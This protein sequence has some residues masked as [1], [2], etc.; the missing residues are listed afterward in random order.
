MYDCLNCG[1][2]FN[3][4]LLFKIHFAKCKVLIKP[5][6]IEDDA[7]ALKHMGYLD[8]KDEV[9][10]MTPFESLS[11]RV[12]I[13]ETAHNELKSRVHQMER[14]LVKKETLVPPN[15]D[16]MSWLANLDITEDHKLM[17]M[18]YDIITAIK[19]ILMEN[20]YRNS[21][22]FYY[23]F[24][25][26]VLIGYKIT[27]THNEILGYKW[28][29]L[30]KANIIEVLDYFWDLFKYYYIEWSEKY[31][32]EI[33]MYVIWKD[34]DSLYFNNIMMPKKMNLVADLA[35]LLY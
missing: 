27:G 26:K 31:K 34:K 5:H 6:N 12:S 25:G 33:E 19:Q 4:I 21:G 7:D 3:S 28:Q 22:A 32:D 29:Y 18:T 14:R 35:L 17:A 16:F 8:D 30:K 9:K 11:L 15:I 1:D 23:D 20:N 24:C 10:T 13:M 2:S